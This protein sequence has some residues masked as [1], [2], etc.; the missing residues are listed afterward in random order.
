MAMLLL[1]E[2]EFSVLFFSQEVLRG[3][4]FRKR[5][6]RWFADRM[7]EVAVDK[8]NPADSWSRAVSELGG[9]KNLLVI[10]GDLPGGLF[11]QQDS[12]ELPAAEQRGAVEM[13]LSRHMLKV[14]EDP[15][16]QFI[17]SPV[18]GAE[19]NVKVNVY[20]FGREGMKYISSRLSS[21]RFRADN[22]FYPLLALMPGD[23]PVHL[24]E[25]DPDFCF[26]DGCW[27]RVDSCRDALA[28]A[29]EYWRNKVESV[30]SFADGAAVDISRYLGV[31]LVALSFI[32]GD[33]RR[34][35][36][37]LRVL[38]AEL[39]PVRF[40]QHLKIT[41]V[42]AM[43]LIVTIG[44]NIGRKQ[45]AAYSSFSKL[46]SQAEDY[47]RKAGAIQREVKRS[48]K[49]QKEMTRVLGQQSGD[50]DIVSQFATL[51]RVLPQTAML[52]WI[53]WSEGSIDLMLQCEE[54]GV[55][56]STVFKH[57]KGWKIDQLQ[58]RQG[59]G[60]AV[61]VTTVKLVRDTGEKKK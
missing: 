45:Y 30:V 4:V 2:R 44:W 11:Y 24:P 7:I 31:F 52:S 36:S 14:P 6:K 25:L 26:C 10:S 60:G 38:P 49:F 17:S 42:L 37:S 27:K 55:N 5:S 29:G 34:N 22:F 46:K 19:G 39:R 59:G 23:A 3:G 56:Y 20:A 8:E 57:F 43:L 21:A 13:D 61:T 50:L 48:L 16:V 51:S 35:I 47:R 28:S 12:V 40:R 32:R 33:V 54:D 15:V 9:D 58:Q 18:A 1:D 53:R 41:A